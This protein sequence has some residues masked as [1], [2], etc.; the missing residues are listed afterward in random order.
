MNADKTGYQRGGCFED[1][2]MDTQEWIATHV[3][4]GQYSKQRAE[5]QPPRGTYTIY[6]LV[7]PCGAKHAIT[8]G[9]AK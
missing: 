5:H 6:K 9:A 1:R 7:C 2:V 8:E 3:G 4:H